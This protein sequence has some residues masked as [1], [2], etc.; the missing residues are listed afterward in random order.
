MLEFRRDGDTL[1]L[2]NSIETVKDYGV[3][4]HQTKYI[5]HY[6]LAMCLW[7]LWDGM[8]RL[9]WGMSSIYS[10]IWAIPLL[11]APLEGITKLFS[12]EVVLEEVPHWKW[13]LWVNS[14]TPSPVSSLLPVCCWD[15]ISEVPIPTMCCHATMS[16]YS[17]EA[18]NQNTLFDL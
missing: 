18:I 4:W 16:S 10:C 5:L 7:G 6:E 3:F 13:A 2:L 12:S 8:W 14:L 17:S 15:V 11:V 1:E 9:T